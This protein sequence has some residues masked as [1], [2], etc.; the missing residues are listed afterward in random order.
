MMGRE[1]K[2]VALDFDYP[3]HEV[4][5]GYAP[6][7][8]AFQKIEGIVKQVPEILEYKGNICSE[9]DARFSD[10]REQARYCVWYNDELRSLW[11]QEPPSGEGCQLWETTTEGSPISPVFETLEALCEWCAEHASVFANVKV[12]KEE[13]LRML[14]DGNVYH[15]SNGITFI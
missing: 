5:K 2:R 15:T 6:D 8:E 3:L 1:L 11:H 14:G 13:W 4:W 7:L 12:S 10:C 9:C